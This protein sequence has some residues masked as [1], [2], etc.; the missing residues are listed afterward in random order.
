VGTA[1]DRLELRVNVLTSRATAGGI[2]ILE[3]DDLIVGDVTL[4]TW[5]VSESSIGSQ[6]IDT[7]SDLR[8]TAGNGSI[9]LESIDGSITLNDG[10]RP[11]DDTAIDADGSGSVTIV[12]G[13]QDSILAINADV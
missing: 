6:V 7:Q 4:K 1:D 2:H 3:T 10:T 8:T 9:S 11:A 12:V 13:G 5:R